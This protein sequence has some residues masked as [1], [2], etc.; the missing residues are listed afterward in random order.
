MGVVFGFVLG[1]PV[2]IGLCLY[3]KSS[4]TDEIRRLTTTFSSL[5]A[6]LE[7]ALKKLEEKLP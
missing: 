1:V 7:N 3:Y 5:V 2:G 6:R 4:I